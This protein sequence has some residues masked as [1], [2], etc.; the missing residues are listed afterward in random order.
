MG[1]NR[2]A[3]QKRFQQNQA[4][5]EERKGMLDD[6]IMQMQKV[7]VELVRDGE[8]QKFASDDPLAK[9]YIALAGSISMLC[10]EPNIVEIVMEYL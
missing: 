4:M 9:Q 7:Q 1:I 3:N 10:Q 5:F 8:A 2:V 6:A